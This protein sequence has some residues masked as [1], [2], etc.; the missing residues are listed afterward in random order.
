MVRD[1]ILVA[2]ITAMCYV[3]GR[4]AGALKI[5]SLQGR[6]PVTRMKVH[7]RVSLSPTSTAS[8][9]A[10]LLD[11]S[12]E[13]CRMDCPNP[14]PINTYLSLRL[15]LSATE[16]PIIVDL[17]AVRWAKGSECGLHFLSIQPPQRQRLLAFVNR[18]A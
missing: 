17:A 10:R 12:A 16:L 15:E 3:S 2:V 11:L 18:R 9:E 5:L 13:G 4:K 6:R 7:Y 14:P 1:V 8:G